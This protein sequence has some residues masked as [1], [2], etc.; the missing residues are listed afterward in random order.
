ME[1]PEDSVFFKNFANGPVKDEA[2]DIIG[3]EV[4]PAFK[5]LHDY[6]FG[7]YSNHLRP[8]P[9]L[10]SIKDK[11]KDL[12]QSFVQYYCAS[13]MIVPVLL[14]NSG[15]TDLTE[16]KTRLVEVAQLMGFTANGGDFSE[17]VDAIK[18]DHDSYF[19]SPSEIMMAFKD[20]MDNINARLNIMFE[21][22]ILG[23]DVFDVDVKPVPQLG[24]TIAYYN[25]PSLDGSRTGT[26]LLIVSMISQICYC[27]IM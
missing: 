24:G 13:K 26:C 9:G 1:N 10:E 8:G 2:L 3:N 16:Y 6:V 23:D 4:L 17:A 14:F 25:P 18:N 11:G 7:Y 22:S 27:L 21:D 15:M 19:G 20:E 12:Y 5:D